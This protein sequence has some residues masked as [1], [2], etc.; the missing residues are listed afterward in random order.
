[1]SKFVTAVDLADEWNVSKYTI[2]D[3]ARRSVDPLP[4]IKL[5]RAV[6]FDP[7]AAQAWLEAEQG[8]AA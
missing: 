7:D 2:Y 4:R 1:M 6:R 5:G 3:W 8:R